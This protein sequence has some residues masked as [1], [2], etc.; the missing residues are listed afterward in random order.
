M[1][2]DTHHTFL[3]LTVI[4]DH[5]PFFLVGG[6]G[7][8]V[9]AGAGGGGTPGPEVFVPVPY[10]FVGK[11]RFFPQHPVH[12]FMELIDIPGKGLPGREVLVF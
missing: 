9:L 1:V 12:H 4:G 3:L 10:D 2:H 11:S 6:G 7:P 8:T 5:T